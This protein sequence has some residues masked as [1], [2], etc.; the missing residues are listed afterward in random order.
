LSQGRLSSYLTSLIKYARDG[1]INYDLVT[2]TD[3]TIWLLDIHRSEMI[4]VIPPIEEK[5]RNIVGPWL[6]DGQGFYVITDLKREY[7]G[8]AFYD[9]S[10]SKLEWILTPEH[11]IESVEL[12]KDGKWR[13]QQLRQ[14]QFW[15]S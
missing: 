9:I 15:C 5:S 3:Y 6:P 7:S 4:Q 12:S 10:K 2:L 13:K 14:W 1:C 11:D 8:L